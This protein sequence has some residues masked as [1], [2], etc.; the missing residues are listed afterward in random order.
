MNI[1]DLDKSKVL[2]TLYNN[3]KPQGLGMLQY[4]PSPMSESEAAALLKESTRFD[5]L[6][7]RVMKVDLSGDELDTWLYNRDNGHNAAEN[8]LASLK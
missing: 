2:A 5:Y 8:A 6:K 3:A 4:S 7:G 1:K